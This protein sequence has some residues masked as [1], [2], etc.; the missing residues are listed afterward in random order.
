MKTS[1]N[2]TNGE[3]L[4]KFIYEKFEKD[5]LSNDDLVQVIELC[6]NLLNLK[7]IPDYS[8]SNAIS[9]NGVK[10]TKKITKLFN[11]KFVIDNL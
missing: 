11:L 6:G 8:K 1:T 9:Y 7:T 3:K 10:K 4:N 5:E 2:T